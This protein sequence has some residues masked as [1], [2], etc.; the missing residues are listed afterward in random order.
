MPSRARSLVLASAVAA[1]AIGVAAC[2][3]RGIEIAESSPDHRAA[4]IFVM[5]CE[6]CHTLDVVG[7]EGSAVKANTREYKDGPNF[8]V[9]KEEKA[10]VLYAIRNGGFSSGPMP[11][12][13]IVGEEADAVASFIAKYSGREAGPRLTPNRAQPEG[14]SGGGTP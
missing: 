13:I 4:E 8:N 5:H 3:E 7:A 10:D 1:S 11:Q 6:A 9:R 2:G 12:D 14:A